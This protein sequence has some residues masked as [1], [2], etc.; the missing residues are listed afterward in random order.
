MTNLQKVIKICA[1]S[2]GIFLIVNI[3][4]A[5]FIGIS[6]LTGSDRDTKLDSVL[7]KITYY[8][9]ITK[10][11]IETSF[12]DLN[13]IKSDEFKIELQSTGDRV[14]I[15]SKGNTL[16]IEEEAKLFRDYSSNGNVIIYLPSD[17]NLKLLEIDSGAGKVSLDSITTASLELNQGVGLITI[18][19]SYFDNC[20]IDGGVGNTIIKR[21][22]MNSF[23]LDAGLG[24]VLIDATLYGKSEINSGVGEIDLTLNKGEELYTIYPEK[25]V[26]SIEIKGEKLENNTSYGN[27]E[28]YIYINGGI[29]S[30]KVNFN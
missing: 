2:F 5:L 6:I 9:N 28:N 26:G 19:N 13:I 8:D 10:I 11:D 1:I 3:F 29:G 7:E 14:K 27:G 23:D 25:G 15:N 24:K 17:L 18:D 12:V 20:S 30:I 22:I 21:T 16:E 4:S